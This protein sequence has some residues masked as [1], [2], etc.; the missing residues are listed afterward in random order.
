MKS[1]QMLDIVTQIFIDDHRCWSLLHVLVCLKT[2]TLYYA[3]L[4]AQKTL[5][6]QSNLVFGG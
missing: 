6:N 4:V 2:C 3:E 1:G 5:R